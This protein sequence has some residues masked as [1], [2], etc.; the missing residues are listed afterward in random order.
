MNFSRQFAAPK[1][2][3]S[4]KDY[5]A[6]NV[7]EREVIDKTSDTMTGK[8]AEYAFMKFCKVN[9]V[10][11]TIDF[12]ITDGLLNVD[13][14]QD[15]T[16]VDSQINTIKC[17]IKGAKSYARWLLIESHKIDEKII[18]AHIYIFV[19]VSIPSGVEN[20]LNL[21]NK[22]EIK[23]EI[24]GYAL[25]SDFCDIDRK[26]WFLFRQGSAPFTP[27]FVVTLFNKAK[28]N[29][30]HGDVLRKSHFKEAYLDL[31]SNSS[32]GNNF[33]NM[34]QAAVVNLSLPVD[35]LRNS[36]EDIKELFSALKNQ[37][38]SLITKTSIWE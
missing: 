32:L 19:K 17:D 8:L 33:L 18:F 35:F 26:P 2:Q 3:K 37:N 5:G 7:P 27:A 4:N 11:I 36:D 25:I 1:A 15:I 34:K 9:G 10:D 29:V 21:Y 31:E 30:L 24:A 20:D 23:A 13:E 16:T 22:N 28:I 38:L 14:G 6:A 12:E